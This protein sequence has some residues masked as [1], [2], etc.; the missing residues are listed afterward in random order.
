MVIDFSCIR[1]RQLLTTLFIACCFYYRPL[2]VWRSISRIWGVAK[3]VIKIFLD[4]LFILQV[5]AANPEIAA[6]IPPFTVS[7]PSI[8]GCTVAENSIF[9]VFTRAMSFFKSLSC[10]EW[11]LKFVYSGSLLSRKSSRKSI[12]KSSRTYVIF[13]VINKFHNR[14]CRPTR[15]SRNRTNNSNKGIC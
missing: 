7:A 1:F 15:G 3:A 12:R 6:N 11:N 8:I 2:E 13:R 10:E 5:C 9:V 14:N 4:F